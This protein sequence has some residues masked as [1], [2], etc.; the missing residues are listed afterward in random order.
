MGSVLAEA[1]RRGVP[2]RLTIERTNTPSL[3]FVRNFGFEV[4]A[5]DAV[6]VV[7][8]RPVSKDRRLQGSR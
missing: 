2:V 6:Y 4:V 5:E 8:E 3:A 7:L 1:D